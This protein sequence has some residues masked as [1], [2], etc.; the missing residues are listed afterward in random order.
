MADAI[1]PLNGYEVKYI[2]DDAAFQEAIV[3][4][5]K[6][7]TLAFDLEFDDNR[8]TYGLTLCLIQVADL[9]TCFLIDPFGIT[10]LKPLWRIIQDP[11]VL[12]I[13]HSASNDILLLKK[14]G[15]QP[16]NIL[17]TE[18]ASKVLNYG[19][20][21]FANMMAALFNIEIDKSYQVSNWNIRPLFEEQ[22]NYAAADVVYL[23]ALKDRLLSQVELLNRLDWVWE[24]C[25]LLEGIEQKGQTDRYLKLR[26]ADRLT[27][28]ELYILKHL[29]DFR[30][31]LAIKLNK[32]SG[33]VIPNEVLVNL[34]L[35]PLTDYRDWQNTKGLM[36][37][38]K[39]HAHYKLFQKAFQE[40]Q[41]EARD[42]N[43]PMERPP[44]PRR[45][46]Y[47]VTREEA[48]RRKS[49]LQPI[50]LK[51][52]EEYGEFAASLVFPQGLVNDYA[53]GKPLE[54]KKK[55]ALQLLT[56]LIQPFLGE[57]VLSGNSANLS[58]SQPE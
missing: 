5:E 26:G 19:R 50:R 25:R 9:D 54:I 45:P 49:R 10:S 18:I 23:H 7:P 21:S 58:G 29:Y 33:S 30:E 32:P 52:I 20:T 2:S 42:L 53:E 22:L 17:D 6:A 36:G 11:A 43:I 14:L 40:A 27:Y 46:D 37:R 3:K 31:S 16:R 24:E 35:E 13:F 47:L 57:E 8:Y 4:L 41:E 38:I 15:C 39:D 1:I 44:R 56:P 12:K 34:V 55:Y 48:E 51:V 28:F